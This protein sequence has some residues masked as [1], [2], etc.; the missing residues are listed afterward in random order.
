MLP[1]E[2]DALT[3]E[4]PSSV[5]LLVSAQPFDELLLD[6]FYALFASL[7]VSEL[8]RAVLVRVV[9]L[10]EAPSHNPLIFGVHFQ[11]WSIGVVVGPFTALTADYLSLTCLCS[12]LLYIIGAIGNSQAES[13]TILLDMRASCLDPTAAFGASFK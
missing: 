9:L 7:K 11:A 12:D 3:H 6:I 4:A 5:L 13:Q 1:C 2:L 8:E 10:L